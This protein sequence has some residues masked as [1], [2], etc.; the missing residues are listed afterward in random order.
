MK[1][2]W[3][4]GIILLLIVGGLYII[5][6]RECK[7]EN[8]CPPK[9]SILLSQAVY[10]SIT[11]ILSTPPKVVVE[12]LRIKGDIVYVPVKPIP[13][14]IPDPINPTINNYEDSL[15][16]KEIDVKIKLKVQGFLVERKW[17]YVP[18]STIIRIDCTK[19]APKI[20]EV[21]KLVKIEKNRLILNLSFGGNQNA[22]LLGGG[23]DILT[24]RGTAFGYFY[25]RFGSSNFHNLKLGIAIFNK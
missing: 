11:K 25:Q 10:D 2:L 22:F 15:V 14:P 20:V 6:L 23:A 12:T 7:K 5:F 18:I 9:G 4:S 8:P 1:D 24:K 17:Q 21:E 13:Q 19:Y 16:N 3:K